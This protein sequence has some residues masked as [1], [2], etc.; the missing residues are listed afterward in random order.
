M[1]HPRTPVPDAESDLHE[2]IHRLEQR[3]A[4][5]EKINTVLIDRVEHSVDSQGSAFSLFQT[6]IGLERQVR[7]RTDELTGTLRKL[8]QTNDALVHAKEMAERANRS[9]TRFVAQAGHDLLQPL[10]AARLSISALIEIQTTEDG[11]RLSRQVDRALSSIENLLKTLL[12]ISKIDAGIV[13]PQVGPVALGEILLG[14]EA[15]FGPVAQRRGLGFKVMNTSAYVWS[16]PLMLERILQ[17]LIAN[18]LRYTEIGRVLVG[19]RARRDTVRIDVIDTGPGIPEDQH[20]AIFEEFHRGRAPTLDAEVGLGLGLSIVQRL[21]TTLDHGITLRSRMGH[22]TRFSVVMPRIPTPAAVPS[23]I[24]DRIG[25][26]WS[27]EGAVVVVI[28]NDPAVLEA[29][30]GLISRWRCVAISAASGREALEET[31]W[32][33]I[34]PDLLLVDYHLDGETGLDAIAQ[35]RSGLAAEI[36]AILVTAD[37]TRETEDQVVAAGLELLRKPVKPAELRALIAHLLD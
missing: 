34:R 22:G 12:D 10:N 29:T 33:G 11:H 17:N 36:P 5:L 1:N 26:G 6:T 3:I 30:V 14:L 13:V 37:Y 20:A 25:S 21:V 9:K 31:V 15:D 23:R 8:E 18:A 28:D 35:V 32:R 2:H 27:L 24:D 4:K 7:L 16:D 19:V